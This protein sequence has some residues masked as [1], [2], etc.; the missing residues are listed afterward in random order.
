MPY[1]ARLLLPQRIVKDAAVNDLVEVGALV[2]AMDETE[3]GIVRPERAQSRLEL[4]DGLLC[5]GRPPIASRIVAGS[6]MHLQHGTIAPA[7]ERSDDSL[8]SGGLAG[9]E[10]HDVDAGIQ[11]D[12]NRPFLLVRRGAMEASCT[13]S[14]HA[15]TLAASWYRSEFHSVSFPVLYRLTPFALNPAYRPGC[16]GP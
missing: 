7:L 14:D 6:Y 5:I 9:N 10:V 2:D 11:G 12:R 16:S 13:E 4:G 15:H 3:V 1:G 8:E